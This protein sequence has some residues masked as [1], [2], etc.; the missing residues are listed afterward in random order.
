MDQVFQTLCSPKFSQSMYSLSIVVFVLALGVIVVAFAFYG[1]GRENA[2]TH[3]PWTMLFATWRDSL[4]ITLLFVSE[5][6][7]YRMSD[8]QSMANFIPNSV[9]LYAPAMLPLASTIIYVLIFAVAGLRIV[10]LTQWLSKRP[11]D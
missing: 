1:R 7:L 3:E 6:L 10:A 4:I 8:F 2:A 11:A 9:L 5:S